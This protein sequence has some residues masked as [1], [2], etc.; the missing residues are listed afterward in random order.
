MNLN[1][2]RKATCV[3]MTSSKNLLLSVATVCSQKKM[4]ANE[5]PLTMPFLPQLK[6]KNFPPRLCLSKLEGVIQA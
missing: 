6:F 2:S 3:E 4:W 1:F 5:K